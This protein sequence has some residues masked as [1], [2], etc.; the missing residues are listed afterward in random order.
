MNFS[1]NQILM[2]HQ[3]QTLA[4][5]GN[6]NKYDIKIEIMYGDCT[7]NL[8]TII[9]MCVI[10]VPWIILH[11]FLVS[12]V[13]IVTMDIPFMFYL[14]G[15]WQVLALNDD[16]TTMVRAIFV[17]K[18]ILLIFLVIIFVFVGNSIPFMFCLRDSKHSSMH[19]LLLWLYYVPLM[20]TPFHSL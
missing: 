5:A 12:V 2:P 11:I 13:A 19:F 18:T 3:F 9:K 10:F 15:S 17:N 4:R 8:D 6:C 14:L 20:H 16:S 1:F 7:C